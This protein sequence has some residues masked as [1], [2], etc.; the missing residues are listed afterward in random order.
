MTTTRKNRPQDAHID[1]LD[2]AEVTFTFAPAVREKVLMTKSISQIL[3]EDELTELAKSLGIEEVTKIPAEEIAKCET[4]KQ[5][6]LKGLFDDPAAQP[7]GGPPAPKKDP[8]PAPAPAPD[9]AGAPPAGGPPASASNVIFSVA[10]MLAPVMNSLPLEVQKFF[11]SAAGGGP[12]AAPPAPGGPPA[13]APAAPA[14]APAAAGG[15]MK[16]EEAVE[17]FKSAFPGVAEFIAEEATKPLLEK[18]EKAEKQIEVLEASSGSAELMEIAKSISAQPEQ[19]VASLQVLKK[20]M[21]A[22]TFKG[23]VESR[24]TQFNAANDSAAFRQLSKSEGATGNVTAEAQITAKAA[25]LRKSDPSL[26]GPASI[27]K[28]ME[29]N[30]ELAKAYQKDMAARAAVTSGADAD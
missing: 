3:S 25:E 1:E 13:P 26:D 4:K 17:I 22:E 15:I 5:D 9:P 28:A 27:R 16:S 6:I 20:S 19:E 2:P 7:P 23:Y 14:P 30:V 18:L 11:Q 8:A 24:R 10:K 29:E 12:A 21:D